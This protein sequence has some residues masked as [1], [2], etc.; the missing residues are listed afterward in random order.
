MNPPISIA[1]YNAYLIS[2]I[3]DVIKFPELLTQAI[4]PI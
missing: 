4:M 1:G 3:V 2:T